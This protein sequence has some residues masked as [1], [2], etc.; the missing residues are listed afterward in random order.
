MP[1]PPPTA[2][3]GGDCCPC[4]CEIHRDDDD[5]RGCSST[6]DMD[7]K[8]TSAPCYGDELAPLPTIDDEN[9]DGGAESM[10]Y[11]Y[12]SVLWEEEDTL[13]TVTG[14]VEVGTKTVVVVSATGYDTR[15][16]AIGGDVGCGDVAGDGCA[17]ANSR[18]GI[19]SD[20]E[21]R[22]SCAPK[23]VGAAGEGPCQIEYAFGEPQDIVDVQV[24]FWKGDERI[25]TLEVSE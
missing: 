1:P 14:A 5:F 13:P 19:T 21:S 4:T 25:R 12:E 16:G 24:A 20:V 2:F 15:P 18:D 7:C 22:W 3:D 10:S 9:D 6:D 8:D 11:S 17:A 23:L